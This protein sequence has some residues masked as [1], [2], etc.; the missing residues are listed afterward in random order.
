M[1]NK[2]NIF[3]CLIV[4]SLLSVV[5]IPVYS[6]ESSIVDIALSDP[7]NFSTLVTALV[8]ADLVEVLNGEGPFT[9][10]A[11]TNDAFD[12]LPEGTLDYLLSDIDALSQ[13]LTY[14]VVLGE[15]FSADLSD[16]DMITTIQG[17]SLEVSID[18]T[19]MIN[20]ATVIT[21][22]IQASNGVIHVIDQVLIP[23]SEPGPEDAIVTILST[24]GGT[25]NPQ[26]GT[27]IYPEDTTITLTAIP[28]DGFRFLYWIASG[29]FTPDQTRNVPNDIVDGEIVSIPGLPS[30]DYLTFTNN[31]AEV[32][33]G[34]GY[35][36]RY[37][38]VFAPVAAGAQPFQPVE[39]FDEEDPLGNFNELSLETATFITVS[40]TVGGSTTP[41]RGKYVLSDQVDPDVTLTATA[42]EGYEFQY[43]LVTGEYMPGH[44]ADPSLDSNVIAENPLNV[45]CG[46]GYSYDYQAVFTLSDGE[47]ESSHPFGLTNELL[48]ALLVILAI[49]ATIGI[50]FGVYVYRR[51]G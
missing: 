39:L 35:T 44:G 21:A 10:F 19:V 46:R 30:T 7:D 32:V 13:V 20:Q 5:I 41:D 26:A 38:A 34:Y 1:I 47:S 17:E 25:T 27:Y 28:D 22:D 42:D 16:G 3:A 45:E 24:N 31:P 6:Q 43:W 9:V 50:I 15:A 14:H 51:K 49:V 29:E 40:S 37:Q 12:D 2:K 11:P 36:Y 33:C 4:A 8:E 23:E 18:G 48:Y